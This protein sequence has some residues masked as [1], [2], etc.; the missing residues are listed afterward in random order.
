MQAAQVQTWLDGYVDAWKSYDPAAIGE[1]FATDAAYRY[2]PWD[3]PVR[4][5]AAI[6]HSWV[7]PS[8]DASGRDAPGTYDAH[9]EPFAVDGSRA[10]AIG[11]SDYFAADGSLAQRYHNVFLLEFDGEGRCRAF[12]ELFG[13]EPGGADR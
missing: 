10:V 11:H 9:Y 5:R 13:L 3:E 12:T 8:G 1:L 2:H 4:G 7:E 6:V